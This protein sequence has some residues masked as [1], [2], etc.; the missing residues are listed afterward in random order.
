ML[1]GVSEGMVVAVGVIV[2]GMVEGVP[3]TCAG[4]EGLLHAETT[5]TLRITSRVTRTTIRR[6]IFPPYHLEQHLVYL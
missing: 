1:V 6:F 5:N 4:A 2:D 3:E